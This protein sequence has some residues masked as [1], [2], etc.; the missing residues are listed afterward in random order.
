MPVL[1]VPEGLQESKGHHLSWVGCAAFTTDSVG[2]INKFIKF[3]YI[4]HIKFY[5]VIKSI[6][7]HMLLVGFFL[8]LLDKGV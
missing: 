8:L 7:H 4:K 2:S 1:C 3:T 6:Y 5:M